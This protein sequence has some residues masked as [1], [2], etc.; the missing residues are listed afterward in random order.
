MGLVPDGTGRQSG[1]LGNCA[2]R[3]PRWLDPALALIIP[4]NPPNAPIRFDP[5][6][7]PPE[8][9]IPAETVLG[10]LGAQGSFSQRFV[11]RCDRLSGIE[12]VL[13]AAAPSTRGAVRMT[14]M[15]DAGTVVAQ[16]EIPRSQLP[17]DGSWQAFYFEPVNGSMGKRYTIVVQAVHNAVGASVNVLGRRGEPYPDGEAVFS[18]RVVDGDATFRYGCTVATDDR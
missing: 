11:S 17:L 2:D 15:D 9:R 7:I 18:D 6:Y 13:R 1:E 4:G 8:V 5:L 14:L 3:G 10:G 12:L 16:Q